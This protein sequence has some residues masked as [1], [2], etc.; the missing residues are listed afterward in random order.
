MK[1][2]FNM[3]NLK[4]NYAETLTLLSY[5]LKFKFAIPDYLIPELEEY[6]L[7]YWKASYLYKMLKTNQIDHNDIK[8]QVTMINCDSVKLY[9]LA[10]NEPDRQI[11]ISLRRARKHWN[12]PACA[13]IKL[14]AP[15]KGLPVIQFEQKEQKKE[16]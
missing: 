2:K 1:E 4:H 5:H 3:Y 9:D 15:R 12:L 6:K 8:Y 7:V 10:L 13:I 11:R 14:P 16:L